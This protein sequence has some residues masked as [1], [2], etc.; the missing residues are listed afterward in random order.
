MKEATANCVGREYSKKMRSLVK[1]KK[2]SE[3]KERVMLDKEEAKSTFVM[4]KY[5]TE[6]KQYYFKKERKI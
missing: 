3:L 6:L 4:K 1:N 2:E 5:E